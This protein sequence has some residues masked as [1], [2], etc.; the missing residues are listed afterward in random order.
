MISVFVHLSHWT[1]SYSTPLPLSRS[2]SCSCERCETKTSLPRQCG[3]KALHHF[4]CKWSSLITEPSIRFSAKKKE[5][6]QS[7]TPLEFF[8]PRS[9]RFYWQKWAENWKVEVAHLLHLWGL[10]PVWR[11][12]A[13][14]FF[15]FLE[16]SISQ[17]CKLTN[18]EAPAL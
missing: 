5:K 3:Q 17:V 7:E 8:H 4:M 2:S 6:N 12:V 10:L 11:S 16:P 15:I 1:G 9:V 18:L 14:F 13:H